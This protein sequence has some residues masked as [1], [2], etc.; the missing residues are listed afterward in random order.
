MELGAPLTGD[1]S[2]G[3]KQ[4]GGKESLGS[5]LSSRMG[6]RSRSKSPEPRDANST[7]PGEGDN[8]IIVTG[9]VPAIQGTPCFSTPA[10]A[11][12]SY[13]FADRAGSKVRMY[14]RLQE[15]ALVLTVP[16]QLLGLY[17]DRLSR[18]T[19]LATT[20]AQESAMMEQ[21]RALLNSYQA[22]QKALALEYTG[23]GFKSSRY[24]ARG[25]PRGGKGAGRRRSRN[26]ENKFL[27]ESA[28]LFCL[29]FLV[30]SLL[31]L[32]LLLV[33]L[34]VPILLFLPTSS[35]FFQKVQVRFNA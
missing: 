31:L 2:R 17:A 19:Q 7:K 15:S 9:R 14:E 23:P 21:Q 32:L 25:E 33:L 24:V 13:Q 5:R 6:T 20:T 26:Q 4:G 28:P 27:I 30:L 8:H 34:S 1:K 10:D 16:L 22:S 29:C 12:G 35:N 11:V 18:I 3:G